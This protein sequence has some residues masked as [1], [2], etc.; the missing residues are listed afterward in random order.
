MNAKIISTGAYLPKKILTNFDLEK[1]VDTSDEWITQRTGIKI[2]HIVEDGESTSDLAYKAA[3]D[4]L[5]GSD[6]SPSDIELIVVATVTPDQPLPATALFV[7]EKLGAY[8]AFGFDIN[9][10]C[11][12]FMYALS[13][14]NAYIKAGMVKNALVIGSEVLSKIVDWTDRTTCVLFGDGAAC[15]LLEAV[16]DENK[17]IISMVM[18]SD[19]RY[20]DLMRVPAPGSAKPCSEEV[21]EGREIYIKMKGNE[22]FKMAVRSIASVSKE[23]LDLVNMDFNDV[24]LMVSHQANKRI[25]ESVAKR[26]GIDE[27]RVIVTI[28]KHANTSAASIPLALDWA[29][30]S[31]RIK[32]GD[33]ILLNSFG[34]SLTWAAGVVRW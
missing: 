10:A 28:D 6:L 34:A 15:V 2:R 1:M 5:K 30:K 26:A 29:Y 27:D 17:G 18:H 20:T 19:G 13:V 23:A 4:A 24:D 14:A 22:T 31:G 9:A 3:L 8:N 7:Q 16:E 11:S 12:G 25:I 32:E 21:I 33:V